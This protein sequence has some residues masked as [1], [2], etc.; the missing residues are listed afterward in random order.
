MQ[1]EKLHA[2]GER[3][4]LATAVMEHAHATVTL[5]NALYVHREF[6]EA[7]VSVEG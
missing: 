4:G 3:N 6:D 5:A 2:I 1:V 7:K